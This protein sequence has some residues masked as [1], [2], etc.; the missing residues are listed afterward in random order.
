MSFSQPAVLI[1]ARRQ[2][3]FWLEDD[4]IDTYGRALGAI[5][6]AIYAYLARRSDPRGVSFPSYGTIA[7]DLNLGRRTVINHIRKLEELGLIIVHRR[8]GQRRTSNIYQLVNVRG[9]EPNPVPP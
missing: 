8:N 2:G 7:H 9:R 6:V 4:V 5:G 1:D 3:W